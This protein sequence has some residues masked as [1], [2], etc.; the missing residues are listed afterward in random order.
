ME[1]G[2][3]PTPNLEPQFDIG[4]EN[5][6]LQNAMGILIEQLIPNAKI[7]ILIKNRGGWKNTLYSFVRETHR[8]PDTTICLL[9]DYAD[10]NGADKQRKLETMQQEIDNKISKGELNSLGS[11]SIAVYEPFIFYMVQKMEAWILSQLHLINDSFGHLKHDKAQQTRKIESIFKHKHASE[12]ANPDQ[13]LADILSY[14]EEEKKGKM[15][16]LHYHKV[17]TA[18]ILLQQLNAQQLCHDFDDFKQMITLLQ[19]KV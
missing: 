5:L 12:I 3:P 18:A 16:K 9:I 17:N 1:G 13:K 8:K 11:Y 7:A 19:E 4:D 15:R 2:N 14:Y 6:P 10:V